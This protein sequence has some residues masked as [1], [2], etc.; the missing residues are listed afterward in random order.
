LEAERDEQRL[1]DREDQL[2]MGSAPPTRS[3]DLNTATRAE[4]MAIPGVGRVTSAAIMEARP[5]TSVEEL[6]GLR[7]IGPATME[8][9]RPWVSVQAE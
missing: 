9:L 1:E 4:L 2:A 5:F 7:G 3:V 6:T 8:N